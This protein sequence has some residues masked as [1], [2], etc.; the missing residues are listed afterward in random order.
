SQSR[1]GVLL[2]A[3]TTL[4]RR[5]C[6]A[7][8][9]GARPKQGWPPRPPCFGCILIPRMM[10]TPPSVNFGNWIRIRIVLGFLVTGLILVALS[11]VIPIVLV[12]VALWALAGVVLATFAYLAYVYYQFSERGGGVQRRLWNLVIDQLPGDPRGQVLD[13]GTG[14][15]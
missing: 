5:D 6:Q 8:T 2:G 9:R 3:K 10:M 12:R 15:G 11:A 1:L 7:G 4:A 13:I 14:N